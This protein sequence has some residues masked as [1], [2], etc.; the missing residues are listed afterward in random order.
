MTAEIP[1]KLSSHSP[2]DVVVLNEVPGHNAAIEEMLD[3]AFGP[4]RFARTAYRVREGTVPDPDLSHV[5]MLGDDMVG[6]VRLSP[7]TIGGTP[8]LF[9][10]PLV[11]RPGYKS[12]GIGLMLMLKSLDAARAAGHRLVI[13]VGDAPYYA[14]AGF[15]RIPHGQVKLPGPVDPERLLAMELVP[16]ALEQARGLARPAPA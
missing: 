15:V 6:S 8:A 3:E 13:L 2:L 4:G 10:G 11:V 5:A 1:A 14:R 12:R 16:G 7:I 9:L